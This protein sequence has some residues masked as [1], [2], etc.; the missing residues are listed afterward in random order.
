MGLT[1]T[2]ALELARDGIT[3]NAVAPG[4]IGTE[5]S[6]PQPAGCS[7]DRGDQGRIPVGRVGRPEEVAA[8][9]AFFL[10]EDAGFVTG[11]VPMSVAGSAWARSDSRSG[12]LRLGHCR[13]CR[14]PPP[15]PCDPA[16]HDIEYRRKQQAEQRHARHAGEHGR[17]R[18]TGASRLYR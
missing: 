16:H 12:P 8:A 13:H 1:R 9:V 14:T 3:V 7:G 6:I 15:Q 11:Q 17:A 10:G 18:A 2:W 5:C 4:P